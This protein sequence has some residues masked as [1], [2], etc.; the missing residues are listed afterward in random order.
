MFNMTSQ[1]CNYVLFIIIAVKH[2]EP[3]EK[4]CAGK[5][6]AQRM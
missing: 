4:L 6:C 5:L 2:V 3:K 1:R